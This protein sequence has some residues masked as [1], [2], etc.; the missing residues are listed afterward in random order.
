MRN[1]LAIVASFAIIVLLSPTAGIAS[2]TITYPNYTSFSSTPSNNTCV[3]VHDIANDLVGQYCAKIGTSP[4]SG[5]DLLYT[6]AANYLGS[7]YS[8]LANGI[9]DVSGDGPTATTGSGYVY[10]SAYLSFSG[11]VYTSSSSSADSQLYAY[12][13]WQYLSCDIYHNCTTVT[14]GT[15]KILI[16]DAGADGN[17]IISTT[18]TGGCQ[19][20]YEFQ[21]SPDSVS[22][23]GGAYLSSTAS[24]SCYLSC[25]SSNAGSD[26]F[27]NPYFMN[28][29]KIQV[30]AVH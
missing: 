23:S 18:C 2:G 10:A 13:Y 15:Q 17:Y 6:Y 21:V 11:Y 26:F 25:S 3:S 8:T 19:Y 27:N 24:S 4:I 5:S 12:V 1:L 22:S 16:W 28:V 14:G 20:A 30:V 7:Q 9:F 29:V